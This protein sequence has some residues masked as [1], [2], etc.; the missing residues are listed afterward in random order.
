LQKVARFR[1]YKIDDKDD[2]QGIFELIFLNEVEPFLPANKPYFLYDYPKIMCPLAKTN[3]KNP[4][5]SEKV[6]L[7]IVGKE[8]ANGYT[9]QLDA[10]KQLEVFLKE[11]AARKKLGKKAIKIDKDLIAALKSGL[12]NVAGIG[13]GIDRLAMI[14]ADAKN[15]SEVNYFPANEM[16]Q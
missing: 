5:V 8:I 7:F 9:E 12:S 14:F 13:M 16:F 6:E 15:I 4:L 2:W 11:Q 3:S 1:G 10:Q